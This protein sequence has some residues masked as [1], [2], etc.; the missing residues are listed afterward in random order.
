MKSPTEKDFEKA[1]SI[2]CEVIK[3]VSGPSASI[4]FV[5]WLSEDNPDHEQHNKRLIDDALTDAIIF[6]SLSQA[7]ADGLR[8][9]EPIPEA[10]ITFASDVLNGQTTRPKAKRQSDR[11]YRQA[12]ISAISETARQSSLY[13]TRNDE[14]LHQ[15]SV[16]DA[17]VSAVRKTTGKCIEYST[18]KRDFY[19]SARIQIEND[20]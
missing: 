14:S 19:K 4:V 5:R 7:I 11:K 18:L 15:L 20:D 12:V 9:K 2:A 6:D 3:R 10:I 17:V 16:L 13:L 1:V 8:Q